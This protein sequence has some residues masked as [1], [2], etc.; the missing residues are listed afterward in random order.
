MGLCEP[1]LTTYW[2]ADCVN[3]GQT[4]IASVN[5]IVQSSCQKTLFQS[6]LASGSYNSCPISMVSLNLGER[7]C[8]I[9]EPCLFI[10]YPFI[11][12]LLICVCNLSMCICLCA[13]GDLKVWFFLHPSHIYPLRLLSWTWSSSFGYIRWP[14]SSW[15]WL[16]KIFVCAS[17]TDINNHNQLLHIGAD[18]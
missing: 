1:F 5:S 4:S 17:V 14:V 2:N 8:G 10:I 3:R 15:N 9:K 18:I 11:I 6:F 12:Y 7:K 16:F 13:C